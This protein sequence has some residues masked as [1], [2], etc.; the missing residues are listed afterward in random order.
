M[1]L[2]R[3]Y[4]KA[5]CVVSYRHRKFAKRTFIIKSVYVTLSL[6]VV[7]NDKVCSE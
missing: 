5:V 7:Y 4:G 6:V 1:L 2:Y 3:T